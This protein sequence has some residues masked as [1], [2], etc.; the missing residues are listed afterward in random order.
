MSAFLWLPE[1]ERGSRLG[2]GLDVR[3]ST[4]AT[5]GTGAAQVIGAVNNPAGSGRI[6]RVHALGTSWL[7][8]TAAA[9]TCD[10][11]KSTAVA[12]GGTALAHMKRR[13]SQP[14]A[15]VIFLGATA[16]DG[17]GATAITPGASPVRFYRET[18]DAPAGN[19]LA[20]SRIVEVTMD[21][22]AGES[23][24]CLTN[25]AAGASSTV[26]WFVTESMA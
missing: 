2:T 9:V 17:G 7:L 24:D 6:V 11:R 5:N 16:S 20:Q 25:I 14:A 15:S 26:C 3:A 18:L 10:F 22:E 19:A 23:I 12:T 8:G 13:T 4:F 21:L 1:S